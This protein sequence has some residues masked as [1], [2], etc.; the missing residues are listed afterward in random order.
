[1]APNNVDD[2]KMLADALPDLKERTGVKKIY[3]DGGYGGEASDPLP[4]GLSID[5][6]QTAIRGASRIWR[7]ETKFSLVDFLFG[8]FRQKMFFGS[9]LKNYTFLNDSSC[10]RVNTA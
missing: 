10:R 6:I 7:Y 5:I 1:M 8:F 3:P 2:D 9:W 4:A